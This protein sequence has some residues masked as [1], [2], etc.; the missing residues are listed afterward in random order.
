[1][2][3]IHGRKSFFEDFQ[4][5]DK[6]LKLFPLNIFEGKFKLRFSYSKN[7]K[8]SGVVVCWNCV[9]CHK[10]QNKVSIQKNQ[11]PFCA[12]VAFFVINFWIV[13]GWKCL[14]FLPSLPKS[15]QISQKFLSNLPLTRLIEKRVLYSITLKGFPWSF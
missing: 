3:S 2:S 11:K 4:F 9:F 6:F 10:Q 8:K 15:C 1:M 7:C 5:F 14:K 13:P 12:G